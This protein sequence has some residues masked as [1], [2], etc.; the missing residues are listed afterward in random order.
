M[1]SSIQ[2]L[3]AEMLPDLMAFSFDLKL[4]TKTKDEVYTEGR[5]VLFDKIQTKN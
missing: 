5:G 1:T 4:K 3:F 2:F